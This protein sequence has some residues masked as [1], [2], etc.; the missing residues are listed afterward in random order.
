M[1]KHL[2]RPA[3][4]KQVMTATETRSNATKTGKKLI[5]AALVN[6]SAV[7]IQ[8]FKIVKG[9]RFENYWQTVLNIGINLK[10]GM[11]AD[12]IF[13]NPTIISG[14]MQTWSIAGRD[15]SPAV[16]EMRLA[17]SIQIDSTSDV[18]TE[19]I[20]KISVGERLAFGFHEIRSSFSN[21]YIS[22][23]WTIELQI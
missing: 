7:E 22:Q 8:L 2:C 5:K 20:N 4:T 14:T 3:N 10:V 21:R 17:E 11:G 23:Y 1:S 18:W 16:L 19:E 12:N 15:I 13:P 9:S 6:I